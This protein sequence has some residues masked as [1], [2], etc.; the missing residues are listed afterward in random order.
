MLFRGLNP[1]LPYHFLS[2]LNFSVPTLLELLLVRLLERTVLMR[3]NR[4]NRHQK[5][6]VNGSA[7]Y[8]A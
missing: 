6:Q 5:L 1:P 4:S 3:E 2:V 7:T 8:L